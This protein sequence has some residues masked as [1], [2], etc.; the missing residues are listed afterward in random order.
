MREGGGGGADLGAGQPVAKQH[1]AHHR[2]QCEHLVPLS[3]RVNARDPAA[4]S[5]PVHLVC[6]APIGDVPSQAGGDV[7]GEAGELGHVV[8]HLPPALFVPPLWL[9]EVVKRDHRLDAR[10]AQQH[11][12]RPVALDGSLVK[13]ALARLDAAPLDGEAV[14]FQAQV[15]HV[16][17][18]LLEP[19][20]HLARHAGA[21]A[22]VHGRLAVSPR[23]PLLPSVPGAVGQAALHLVGGGGAA[24]EKARREVQLLRPL[25]GL[26]HSVGH[27]RVHEHARLWV[28]AAWQRPVRN[29]EDPQ[30]AQQRI[31][32]V[33]QEGP[34]SAQRAHVI[35]QVHLRGLAHGVDSGNS[36]SPQVAAARRD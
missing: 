6:R 24:E 13:L 11:A 26:I 2:A 36:G 34:H 23:L 14:A 20:P 27:P 3:R 30:V 15:A 28:R 29:E 32:D 31:H 17:H 33:V 19:A 18:V 8:A 21:L 10:L 4:D 22:A 35:K 7:G 16:L 25:D 9:G 5:E 12:P 1:V